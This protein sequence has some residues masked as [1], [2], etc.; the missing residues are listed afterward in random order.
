MFTRLI[1]R[2]HICVVINANIDPNVIEM[3]NKGRYF[4]T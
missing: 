1:F 4:D 2:S 3:Q